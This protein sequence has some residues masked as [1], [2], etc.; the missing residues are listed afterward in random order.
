M[1][2][3]DRTKNRIVCAANQYGDGTI[4]VG[5]RHFDETMRTAMQRIN[6]DWNYWKKLGH[7][8]GF[9]DKFGKFHDREA[10]WIIAQEANQIWDRCG[11][12]GKELFSENLY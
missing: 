3:R 6:P 10:A 4:I 9:I 5:P 2:N 11:G 1:S 8:Q 12:D 7:V